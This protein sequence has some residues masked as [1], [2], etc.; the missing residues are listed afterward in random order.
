MGIIAETFM[1]IVM[2]K[3]NLKSVRRDSLHLDMAYGDD[4][5]ETGSVYGDDEPQGGVGAPSLLAQTPLRAVIAEEFAKNAEADKN[6]A[7]P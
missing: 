7:R 6:A 4:D 5:M 2:D 3:N 1:E